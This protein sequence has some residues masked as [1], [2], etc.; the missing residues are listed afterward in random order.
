MHLLSLFKSK[1]EKNLLLDLVDKCSDDM[2]VHSE[3]VVKM[4]SVAAWCLQSDFAKRPSMSVVVKVLEGV[5]DVDKS[6]DYTFVANTEYFNTI[7]KHDG[8]STTLIP[9]V[10]SGPR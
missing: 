4:M 10:L 9:S 5:M 1:G 7:S 2:K 6:M 3:E 8:T